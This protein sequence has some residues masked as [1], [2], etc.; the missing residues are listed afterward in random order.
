MSHRGLLVRAAFAAVFGLGGIFAQD[1]VLLQGARVHVRPGSVLEGA[2][3]LVE[4]GVVKAVGKDLK[5]A[6]GTPV[7]DLAG[8]DLYPGF[9]D[10]L[11]EGLLEPAHA[12][13]GAFG[14]SDPT[15][16]G[17][18]AFLA[19]SNAELLRGGVLTVGLGTLPAGIRGGVVSVLA[20]EPAAGEPS[21]IAKNQIVPCEI[22]A[23]ERL[24]RAGAPP[25]PLGGGFFGAAQNLVPTT[26]VLMR[27]SAAKAVD[28]LLEGA[29]RY[30]ESWEKYRKDF[31]E[32]EKKLAEWEK[33][34]PADSKPASRPAPEPERRPEGGGARPGFPPD[35][36]NWPRE[37]RQE[38]MRENMGGGRRPAESSESES[39][40]APSGSGKPK[41]PE[42]PRVDTG[43]EAL[44]RVLKREVPLWIAAHW[45]SDIDAALEIA[46][47]RKVRIVLFGASE[48]ARRLDA[49]RDARIVVALGG[50]LGTDP[51]NLDRILQREDLCAVLARAGI[52]VTFFSA[53]DSAMGPAGLPLIAAIAIGCGMSEDQALAAVTVNAARALG[54]EKKLGT[55]EPD[56]IAS[57]FSCRGSPFAPGAR[58][59][60]VWVR[61]KRIELEGS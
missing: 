54:L 41:P 5:A 3:V 21:I 28:E 29:R 32:Y 6:E 2:D 22:S 24:P 4:K 13:R 7:V 37:K 50:P 30:R 59:T 55:I 40:S 45:A 26:S 52:P 51:D 20:V 27:E 46:R 56:R 34:K 33:N 43:K 14:G 8:D 44:V 18:D 16:D 53:G 17:F 47:N 57:L 1:S 61:G 10:P 11:N 31:A 36:R 15:L 38:W 23:L 35:F 60:K 12:G 48:A 25:Q 58:A 19:T 49:I 42:K 39:A 9:V